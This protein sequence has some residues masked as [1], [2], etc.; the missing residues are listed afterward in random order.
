MKKG[1]VLNI[2]E[3]IKILNFIKSNKLILCLL[4][5]FVFGFSYGI[6][7]FKNYIILNNWAND[8]ILNYISLRLN[9]SVFKIIVVSFL[10]SM[11]FICLSF[12]S[13]TS[14]FGI[15]LSP[16]CVAGKGFLYGVVSGLLYSNYSFKGVAFHAII[17]IPTATVV[18]IALILSACESI[19]FSLTLTKLTFPTAMPVNLSLIF[20][21]YCFK[22]LILSII[23]LVSAIIAALISINFL[24]RFSL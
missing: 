20:K 19:N 16:I 22:N 8:Y 3:Y 4:I 7:S 23:V 9:T 17:F 12:I 11:L 6:F 1:K 21:N 15:I 13:G 2:S 10:K 14:I 18:T 24:T 5:I